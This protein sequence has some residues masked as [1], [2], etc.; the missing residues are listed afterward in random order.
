LIRQ[1]YPYH[2]TITGQFFSE[3]ASELLTVLL[4]NVFVS[5][6]RFAEQQAEEW[7]R[8]NQERV[9]RKYNHAPS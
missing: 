3:G 4:L 7:W 2:T 9:F 1:P 5:K 8:E 6:R